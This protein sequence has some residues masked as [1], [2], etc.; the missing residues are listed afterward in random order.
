MRLNRIVVR[1]LLLTVV[2]LCTFSCFSCG[3]NDNLSAPQIES[4][5]NNMSTQPIEQVDCSYPQQTICLRGS[6]FSGVGKLIVNGT[7]IDLTDT[8]IYNTDNSIIIALPKEVTTTTSTGLAYLQVEN[9]VGKAVYEP[10]YVFDSSEKPKITSFSSTVLTPGSTLRIAGSNLGGA[11]EV[12]VPLAFGQKVLC[13]FDANQT[14]S[15]AEIFVIVPQGV[16]FAQ[17]Q[18]EIVMHKT[19][20]GTGDE[21][22]TKAYS[23]VTNFS[24]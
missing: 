23:D 5:W 16:T 11:V 12:Y 2:C 7:E 15:D 20:A 18:V 3:D 21:Y 4:V 10:F 9:A 17:G 6:G 24:N 14:S 8:K 1:V 13:E 22:T 19:Y